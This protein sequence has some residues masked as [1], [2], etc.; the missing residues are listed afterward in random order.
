MS[1]KEELFI[2]VVADVND[3]D[4]ITEKTCIEDYSSDDIKSIFNRLESLTGSHVYEDNEEEIEEDVQDFI[5]VMD[6]EEVHTIESVSI[7]KIREVSLDDI[8]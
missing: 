4:Y 8:L 5:P 3:G 6:N 1:K 7:L 2:E